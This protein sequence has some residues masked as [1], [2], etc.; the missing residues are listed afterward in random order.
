MLVLVA[1]SLWPLR[2]SPPVARSSTGRSR[3]RRPGAR[4]RPCS[5]RP[6]RSSRPGSTSRRAATSRRSST[7]PARPTPTRQTARS[8]RPSVPYR[9]RVDRPPPGVADEFNGT[10]LVEWQNVTAGYDLDALWNRRHLRE[11]YAWV[12]VSA[13]RVGVNQLRGWSPTR[14]GTLDVTGGGAFHDRPALVRHLRQT[15]PG[16][17]LPGAVDL[18]GRPRRR[19]RPRGRRLAVGRADGG[20]LQRR[21]TAGAAGVRRLRVRR[22]HRADPGRP[23]ADH[24][25]ALGDRRHESGDTAAGQTTCSAAGRSPAPRTPAG[26]DR[27]T[28]MP[29]SAET[30]APRRSTSAPTRRSAAYR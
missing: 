27:S 6:T 16:D 9:T 17:P 4:R 18:L 5:R 30:S 25:G 26:R 28:G 12:G 21:A 8:S 13:Q 29:L 14:Y 11:G 15:R 2:P 1:A 10:V 24:P 3:A 22:R 20:L 23:G 19:A 7:S